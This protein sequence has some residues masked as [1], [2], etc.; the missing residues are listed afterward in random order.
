MWKLKVNL[1]VIVL[2]FLNLNKTLNW[3]TF[4][5]NIQK[6]SSIFWILFQRKCVWKFILI[7]FLFILEL[8]QMLYVF[9]MYLFI[10]LRKFLAMGVSIFNEPLNVLCEALWH[11]LQ[12]YLPIKNNEV[13]FLVHSIFPLNVYYDIR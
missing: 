12:N 5:A 9:T 7:K 6:F 4:F 1:Q 13:F 2:L 3:K 11:E 8:I 10:F